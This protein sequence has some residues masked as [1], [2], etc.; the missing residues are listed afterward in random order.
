MLFSCVRWMGRNSYIMS[1]LLNNKEVEQF[2]N[3]GYVRL[4]KVF[5]KEIA[6]KVLEV[7]WNDLPFD[8][9]DPSTWNEPVVR[10]GMYTDRPFVDSVNTQRLYRVFDQLIGK[11][12][13][14][15]CGSV[16]TFP[17]RFPSDKEPNDT[18]KHVD[19][20]FPGEDP[21]NFWEW[22]V[23]V[24]SKGRALL[25]LVL[26][27]D[28]GQQDAPTILYKGSHWDVAKLLSSEGD[29]GLSFMEL[30]GRLEGLSE[31]E[32]AYA[33]GKTGT[34]Y[35][36]HPFMVHAAQGHKGKVPKFMAQPPLLIRGELSFEDSDRDLFP[37]E[38]AIR[39]ALE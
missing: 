9:S 7:L 19:A 31:R 12:R 4:D 13:W 30:A 27:S 22:R 37:V 35:L 14:I 1:D 32:A 6:D 38:K 33:V 20:G 26:Y 10:L 23:N 11:D 36:C 39:L 5:S 29:A 17:V 34:V 28:V 16:G 18:G 25:M 8:R 2:I 15:P 21:G 24:K 3:E